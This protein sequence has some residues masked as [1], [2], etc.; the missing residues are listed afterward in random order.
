MKL[1]KIKKYSHKGFSL[2][3]VMVS[4]AVL[5]LGISAI[6]VLMT[7]NIRSAAEARDQAIAVGLANESI[8]IVRNFKENTATFKAG[9]KSNGDYVADVNSSYT[10][11]ANNTNKRLYIDAA[12]GFYLHALTPPASSTASK[13][14]RKI[15]LTNGSGQ[16]NVTSYVSWNSSGSFSPCTAANKC[17]YVTSI[18]TDDN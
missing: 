6:M 10:T 17:I 8:E 15:T 7:E 14:Y 3:E 13:F 5:A 18:M 1:K 9:S 2:V 12:S 16:I 4:M 11:F